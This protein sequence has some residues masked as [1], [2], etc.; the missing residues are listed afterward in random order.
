ME[1]GSWGPEALVVLGVLVFAAI[2]ARAGLR[3][4]KLPAVVGYLVLGLAARGLLGAQADTLRPSVSVLSDIGITLLLFRVGLDVDPVKLLRSVP[5]ALPVWLGD[6]A[7][8]ASLGFLA[9]RYLLEAD[10]V[11]SLFVA[12]SCSATSVAVSLTV[13]Q[14]KGA[15]KSRLARELLTV[16]ELDDLSAV[17]LMSLLFA[18]APALLGGGD[19]GA[20]ASEALAAAGP[21]VLKA[22]VLGGAC[23]LLARYG[24]PRLSSWLQS[25]ESPPDSM[26]SMAAVGLVIAGAAAWLGFSAAVGALFAGLVFSRDPAAIRNEGY[27][28]PLLSLFAPFFFISIGFSLDLSVLPGAAGDGAWLCLAAAVGKMGGIA[29]WV[30]PRD[31]WR[32]GLVLGLSMVPRAEIAT[33]VAVTGLSMGEAYVPASLYAA[34]VVCSALTCLVTPVALQFV[35]GRW[36]DLLAAEDDDDDD[37]DGHADDGGGQ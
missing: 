27:L 3:R 19:P 37:D 10:V 2:S 17:F 32:A 11:P 12:V 34:V 6:V 29:L 36:P 21:M 35:L 9:A 1:N 26:V 23:L 5:R 22:G 14:E 8:S 20:L 30:V 7:V 4:I 18:V 24:E 25:Q 13:W 16:A 28:E 15:T 31:G 33:I